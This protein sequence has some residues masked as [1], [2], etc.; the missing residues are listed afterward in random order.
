MINVIFVCYGNICRSPSAEF[1][2]KNIVKK[3]NLE[4]KFN[5]ISRGISACEQGHDLYYPSKRML[6]QNHIPYNKHSAKKI[7]DEDI[8]NANYILCMELSHIQA[9]KEEFSF[10]IY[11]DKLHLLREYSSIQ[12]DIE[13][14]YYYKNY[15]KVFDLIY[16][17]CLDFFNYLLQNN[18]IK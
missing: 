18:L 15:Q 10:T 14:P 7:D 1:I 2:F 9:I 12:G 5:I 13:D 11:K 17:S 6:E 8:I 4:D 16:S 3:Y